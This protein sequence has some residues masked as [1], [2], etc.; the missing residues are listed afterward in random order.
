MALPINTNNNAISGKAT[1]DTPPKPTFDTHSDLESR[2]NNKWFIPHASTKL[3]ASRAICQ[4][5][6]VCSKSER[7]SMRRLRV[8][9]DIF[10]I[11]YQI[12]SLN[13]NML[14]EMQLNNISQKLAYTTDSYVPF[15]DGRDVMG[16]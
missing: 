7:K 16:K 4:R 6:A 15:P 1:R 14:G 3:S 8:E 10:R 9:L 13:F 11:Q 12:N 5:I 2:P